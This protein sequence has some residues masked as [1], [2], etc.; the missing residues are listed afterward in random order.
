MTYLYLIRHAR[1]TWNAEGRMQGHA[2][3]PLDALGLKQAHALGERFRHKELDAVY[4][5]PLARARVTAEA[6]AEPHH[7]TVQYDERLKERDLGEWTGLTG[8]EANDRYP[9]L[10]TNNRWR[11]EGPPGGESYPQLMVR[12]ASAFEGILAAQPQGRVAVISHG[13]LLNAYLMQLLGISAESPIH[14]HSGNTA[15]ARVRIEQ[16]HIHILGLGD[17]RHLAGL[18]VQ[19]EH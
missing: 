4:S 12:A 6:L 1:S 13:G 3:P 8:D 19:T 16:G 9:S 15:I 7:L 10:W 14:F 5:S 18:A 17:D 2:D 11:L